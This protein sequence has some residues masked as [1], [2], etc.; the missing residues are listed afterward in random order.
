[1]QSKLREL[2]KSNKIPKE[3][4]PK[5]VLSWIGGDDV[6]IDYQ[7]TDNVLK[8]IDSGVKYIIL[9]KEIVVMVNS[10]QGIV[11][12]YG[13]PNIPPRPQFTEWMNAGGDS[14]LK[15]AEMD[16]WDE[17]FGSLNLQ[18][19]NNDPLLLE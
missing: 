2:L 12:Y 1:M 16:R 3:Y 15:R 11:P 6:V 14:S 7:T 5:Y 19:E 9:K 4:Q 10:I 18:L 17:I 8:A 13:I